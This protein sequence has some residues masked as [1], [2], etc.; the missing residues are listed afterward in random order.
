MDLTI[1]ELSRAS[2]LS[3]KALRLYDARGLLRPAHVDPVTGYRRY[4]AGQVEQAR[5]VALLRRI[6][7]PLSEIQALLADDA[8]ARAAR[9][10]AWWAARQAEAVERRGAVDLL[11]AALDATD[12]EPLPTF[13][14]ADIA[15]RQ[16]PE[17][18]VATVLSEVHQADL[19]ATFTAAVL[20]VRAHLAA[21]GARYD[22][23]FWVIYHRPVGPRDGLIETC[24]PYEGLIA[25]RGP[26]ALRLEPAAQHA[27]V[28]LTAADCRYPRIG[29]AFTAVESWAAS[30]GTAAGPLRE[31]YPGPW[32]DD[33]RV[34][35]HVAVPVRAAGTGGPTT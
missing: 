30:Q 34:V 5:L 13:T 20:T 1:G 31:I 28:A 9:V 22:D 3:L 14:A 32:S 8:A 26:L 24:V 11:A 6:D 33:G 19:V 17:R 21:A 35:A 18:S 27:S 23:E 16:M 4:D 12:A 25:P 2:G 29:A 15:M 7:M 10:T